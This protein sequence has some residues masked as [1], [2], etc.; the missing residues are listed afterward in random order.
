MGT[1]SSLRF[2]SFEVDRSRRLL[3]RGG[4]SVHLSPKAL[5]L[6]LTLLERWPAA[7]SKAEL[8][9]AIWPDTFVSETTLTGV[10]AELRAALGDD[11][12]SPKLIRT[13]HGFG[14]AFAGEVVAD[15]PVLELS[16]FRVTV[17]GR[18]VALQNG[19]N[20]IGRYADATVFIDD[21]SVSRVH[22]AI[23]VG[24]AAVVQ[25]LGSKNGTFV[26]GARIAA[27]QVLRNRDILGVGV[28]V[29]TFHDA[30]TTDSTMTVL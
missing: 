11:A 5:K 18:E 3:L 6:L 2:G 26:N 28:V 12:R 24:D 23:L 8:H 1:S 30:R 22:A 9:S 7:A 15:E 21:A 19:E 14:Y 4:E 27:P 13:L 29:M 20:L 25:D 10:A 16:R 17:L